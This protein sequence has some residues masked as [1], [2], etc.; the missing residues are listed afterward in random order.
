MSLVTN[1]WYGMY[2]V[3]HTRHSVC[4]S[5]HTSETCL[6]SRTHDTEC[7]MFHIRDIPYVCRHIRVWR[8]T[9]ECYG[10]HSV[11]LSSHTSVYHV[12][13]TS[14]FV[15]R[16]VRDKRPV[17]TFRM[18]VVTYEY[19]SRF[20]YECVRDKRSS[21]QE[22]CNDIPYVCRHIRV[23]IMF[24]IRD[25]WNNHTHS[26]VTYECDERHTE[27]MYVCEYVTRVCMSVSLVTSSRISRHIQSYLS[28]HPVVSLVTSSRISRHIQS[29]LLMAHTEY[30]VTYTLTLV[31]TLACST[32]VATVRIYDDTHSNTH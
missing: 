2:H 9:Y 17:M 31:G 24:H 22:T 27:S 15:T 13:H 23:C 29:Y 8:E 30:M 28:S 32:A 3:S 10:R 26:L 4:L 7:I 19:V 16:G 25:P 21:W 14:V 1:S 12:S 11:C 18:S 20:T 5:S 6:L